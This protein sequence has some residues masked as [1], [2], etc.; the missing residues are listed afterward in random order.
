MAI[1]DVN[2]LDVGVV[3]TVPAGSPAGVVTTAVNV[4][5]ATVPLIRTI[6]GAME[7]IEYGIESPALQV[8]GVTATT[9]TLTP[10]ITQYLDDGTTVVVTESW[11]AYAGFQTVNGA[12]VGVRKILRFALA[13][14][15]TKFKV[16]ITPS[17][18]AGQITAGPTLGGSRKN[19]AG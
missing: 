6:A 11:P 5:A 3:N 4:T 1:F 19:R 9:G 14:S 12:V 2:A 17:G 8:D 13:E 18:N 15:A 10:V 7:D 16:V